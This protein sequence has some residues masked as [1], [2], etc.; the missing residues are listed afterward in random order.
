MTF[1]S[2]LRTPRSGI[3]ARRLATAASLVAALASAA[4]FSSETVIRVKADGSGTIEQVNLANK[5]LIGMAA[6]MAKNAV[7]N[8]GS[9][10]ATTPNLDN[11]GDLFDDAKIREQAATWGEGVR[12]VSSEPISRDGLSGARAIFA[13]DDIR[14]L[15]TSNG[16]EGAAG[17]PG[18]RLRFDLQRAAGADGTSIVHIRLPQGRARAADAP[19]S[20][21]APAAPA[22]QDV[23]PEALAMVRGMFK[24]ARLSIAVEVDGAIVSTDA[25][26]RDGSRA[27]IF[28]L[29][30]DQLLSDPSKLAAMQRIKPGTDFA[31]AQEALRGVPGVVFPDSPTVSIEFK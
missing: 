14:L 7:R 22:P 12:Y 16:R 28:A 26:R 13:F 2:T 31:T 1:I 6:G 29:D 4:C 17:P 20:D 10:P 8:A 5:E 15:T 24:G 9:D 25:P 27:T 21:A 23:P 30:F 18:P 19:P 11:L 3:A